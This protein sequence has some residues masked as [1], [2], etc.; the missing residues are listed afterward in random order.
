MFVFVCVVEHGAVLHGFVSHL[1]PRI[2]KHVES[3]TSAVKRLS[4]QNFWLQKA[5]V[6]MRIRDKT[7]YSIETASFLKSPKTTIVRGGV[8]LKTTDKLG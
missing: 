6:G 4:L 7:A 5:A 2:A 3:Q 1:A 8:R